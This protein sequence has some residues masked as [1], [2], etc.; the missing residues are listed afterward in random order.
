MVHDQQAIGANGGGTFRAGAPDDGETEFIDSAAGQRGE[1]FFEGGGFG[2]EQGRPVGDAAGE[3]NNG[4]SR[5]GQRGDG[6]IG[7]HF[8]RAEAQGV[9]GA[10][11]LL[12][13]IAAGFEDGEGDVFQ[14]GE[15]RQQG[16]GRKEEAKVLLPQLIDFRG[17]QAGDFVVAE[18]NLPTVRRDEE[19]EQVEQQIFSATVLAADGVETGFGE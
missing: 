1:R 10:G 4:T 12:G 17:G 15:G 14:D 2:D 13:F 5:C 8:Q 3:G 16:A 6:V 19:S 11:G 18:E 7:F 9:E